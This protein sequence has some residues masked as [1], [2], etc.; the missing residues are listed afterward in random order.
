MNRS[1]GKFALLCA[2]TGAV[3][4][5]G[6]VLLLHLLPFLEPLQQQQCTQP[7]AAADADEDCQLCAVGAAAAQWLSS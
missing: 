5:N 4:T 3:D 1:V 6:S 7:A 2:G